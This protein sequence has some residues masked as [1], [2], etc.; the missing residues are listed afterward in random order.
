MKKFIIPLL[1]A[2]CLFCTAAE[3]QRMV[4]PGMGYQRYHR[5]PRQKRPARQNL[6]QFEPSVNLSVGYG[7]PNLDKDQLVNFQ[8]Y[9]KGNYTQTGPITGAI[10]YRFSPGMC[11]GA[12]VMHGNVSVPYYDYTGTQVMK[13]S[14]ESWTFMLN[15]IRYIPIPNAK[16]T[17]Y[18][19]TAIGF[20]SWTQDYTETSGIKINNIEKPSDLAYQAG[21]G[22]IFNL[23]KNA[24]LFM[25]AGYGKYILHG[26]LTFK[27]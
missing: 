14:L 25:E 1:M 11:I 4:S 10:D 15:L 24:G 7:F 13:G 17:P 2:G 12:I 9:Y 18:I 23:S 20:N 22:A 26:G 6:V 27:F 8:P 21:I 5:Y 3:A 19:R 16:V